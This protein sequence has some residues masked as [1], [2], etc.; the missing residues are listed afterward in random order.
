[1]T[2]TV[3]LQ[4]GTGNGTMA[5]VNSS[6]QL[7]TQSVGVSPMYDAMLNGDAFSWTA[8]TTDLAAGETALLVVNNSQT[9]KLVIRDLYV[10]SDV[11]TLIK[12]HVPAAAT[13]AGTAVVGV[14]LNR[15][16]AGTL[17]DAVAYRAETDTTFADANV[18]LTVTTNELASDQFGVLVS[19]LCDGALRLGYDDAVACFAVCQKISSLMAFSVFTQ[20]N[21]LLFK[22]LRGFI[23]SIEVGLNPEHP[24]KHSLSLLAYSS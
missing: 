18:V 17:A 1:M 5:Q 19:P 22:K 11:P 10:Y 9:R 7:L 20:R 8:V 2:G 13:W 14:N 4:D 23:H 24:C 6:N 16:K 12:I 21:N 3:V 15:E